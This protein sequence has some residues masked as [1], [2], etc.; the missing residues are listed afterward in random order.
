MPVPKIRTKEEVDVALKQIETIRKTPGAMTDDVYYKCLVS[1][2][3]EYTCVD[4]QQEALVQL[5]R[6]PIG[7]YQDTLF[8][9]MKEDKMYA[10]LVV[11]FSYKLIQMGVVEGSDKLFVP[12]MALAEA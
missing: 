11:L 5:S 10:E 6:V 12:T 1:L 3:Y 4:E 9:Q 8:K 7:Y 2:G